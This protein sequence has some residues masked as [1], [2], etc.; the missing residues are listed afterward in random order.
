[1]LTSFHPVLKALENGDV[2]RKAI[3]LAL[4]I[5]GILV[6]VG[7]ALAAIQILKFSFHME[8]SSATVGGLLLSACLLF[9]V[10]CVG[11]IYFYRAGSIRDLGESP[12]TVIPIFSILLR[13]AGET[14]AT[15]G[16]IVGV[17]GCLFI[18][19]AQIN[20]LQALGPF[21]LVAPT[22]N[23]D[24]S[25]VGGISFLL[26]VALVSL[27][28]LVVFY[29]LAEAVVVLA[30]VARNV[31]LLAHRTVAAAY[32]CASCGNAIGADGEFCDACGVRV[33]RQAAS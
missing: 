25:F 28:A 2:I 21:A 11:Q 19:L 1:L 14:Y 18:W 24:G 16:V 3:A 31:H 27:A 17:G 10:A 6:L 4:R 26:Y 20:P 32:R 7:G 13:A 12:F 23:S 33:R 15:L 9:G 29:F 5:A 8:S 22:N 30:D